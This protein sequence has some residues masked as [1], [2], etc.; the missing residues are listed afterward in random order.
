[1]SGYYFFVIVAKKDNPIYE[2]EFVAN[3]PAKISS[4]LLSKDSPHLSQFIIHSALDVVEELVW[5]S[6]N[7]YLKTIDKFNDFYISAYVTPGH[8]KFMILH[9]TKNEDGIKN[10]IND[11]YELFVK[12]QLNPFYEPNSIIKSQIFDQ[13][14]KILGKK[15]L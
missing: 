4:N 9:D 10:F 3:N 1:M 6:Q 15:H 13:R 14:V 5:T 8:I 7:M 2:T 11:V 12:I